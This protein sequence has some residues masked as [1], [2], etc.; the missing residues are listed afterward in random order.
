MCNKNPLKH[1]QVWSERYPLL[2][3]Y[4]RLLF[5]ACEKEAGCKHPEL[6]HPRCPH[7]QPPEGTAEEYMA[8][9]SLVEALPACVAR[10]QV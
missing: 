7:P 3:T 8:W 1:Q 2:Y 6:A 4:W 9:A 5:A 10:V